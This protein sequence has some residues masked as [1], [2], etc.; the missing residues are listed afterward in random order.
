MSRL[1]V[2]LHE[3]DVYTVNEEEQTIGVSDQF[4][5]LFGTQSAKEAQD[6][7]VAFLEDLTKK[8]QVSVT[9]SKDPKMPY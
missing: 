4:K 8:W 9:Y 1:T 6:Q 7:L 5:A 3:N 2:T